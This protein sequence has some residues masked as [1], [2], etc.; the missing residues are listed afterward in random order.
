MELPNFHS[1]GSPPQA[2][3]QR[4]SFRTL[5]LS[6][7]GSPPQAWGQL[8][9]Y[10]A[11]T[12]TI[13]GSPPQAWGQLV[14]LVAPMAVADWFTPTGVGT[15]GLPESKHPWFPV[16]PHRRGDNDP[17][18]SSRAWP[19]LRFTPT[20]VGTTQGRLKGIIHPLPVHPHRRGDN[21]RSHNS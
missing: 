2:W 18:L 11:G 1:D 3:G 16:H 8:V 10:D 20:G 13:T 21:V 9:A 6:I 7:V 15:T 5:C 17:G 12:R 14:K 19:Y 4:H